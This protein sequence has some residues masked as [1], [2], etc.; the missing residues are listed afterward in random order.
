MYILIYETWPSRTA[1]WF[2]LYRTDI[3]RIEQ[4]ATAMSF[5]SRHDIYVCFWIQP[6]EFIVIVF[7]LRRL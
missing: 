3:E 6:I 2:G 5:L 4:N 1:I 7:F